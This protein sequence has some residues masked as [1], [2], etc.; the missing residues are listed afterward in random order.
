M[1]CAKCNAELTPAERFC[2]EGGHPV[3]AAAAPPL[4]GHTAAVK[5]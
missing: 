2:G 3:E 1:K 4:G 5:A